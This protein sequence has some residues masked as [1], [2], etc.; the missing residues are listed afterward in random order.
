MAE[1]LEVGFVHAHP[2]SGSFPESSGQAY[3]VGVEV[4]D[5][6]AF[7]VGHRQPCGR[8]ALLQRLPGCVVVPAGVDQDH[9]ARG[10]DR[11]DLSVADREVRDRNGDRV[12]SVAD[13]E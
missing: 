9:A 6:N 2:A 12:Y 7:D 11:I 8:E 1:L 13:I 3:M 10:L 4:G 5:D